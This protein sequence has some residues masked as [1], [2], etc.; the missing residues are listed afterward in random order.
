MGLDWNPITEAPKTRKGRIG[1]QCSQTGT[2]NRSARV[3]DWHVSSIVLES[4]NASGAFPQTPTPTLDKIPAPMDARFLSS[5]GFG[6]GTRIGRTRLFPREGAN[7][8]KLTVKKIISITRFFFT[9]YVPYKPWK[10]LRKP[11]K[12]GTKNSPFFSSL[13]FHR[14]RPVEPIVFELF[15]N[16]FFGAET[17]RQFSPGVVFAKGCEFLVVSFGEGVRVGFGRERGNGVGRVGGYGG[18]RR[19]NRQVNVH[20]FVFPTPILDKNRFP[21]EARAT[22][23]QWPPCSKPFRMVSCSTATSSRVGSSQTP[24]RGRHL[25]SKSPWTFR[26]VCNGAGPI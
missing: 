11:W 22:Y 3:A 17:K 18:D 25:R 26:T 10:T 7:R 21:N 9:V 2:S 23:R 14:L 15:L 1:L 12:I 16:C 24:C 13:D 8:E 19:R 6:F 5:V 4:G 20:G